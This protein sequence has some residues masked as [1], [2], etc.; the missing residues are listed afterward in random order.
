[1]PGHWQN[2]Q[3]SGAGV[4]GSAVVPFN[5][6]LKSGWWRP[7]FILAALVMAVFDW[8]E[9]IV[10]VFAVAPVLI[11]CWGLARSDRTGLVVGLV[12][13]ALA[14]WI[15][16]PRDWGFSGRWVP[17]VF[18]VCLFLPILTVVI[19]RIGMRGVRS[20]GPLRAI[21]LAAFAVVGFLT[22]GYVALWYYAEGVTGG[23]GVWPGPSGLQVVEGPGEGGSG[24]MSRRLDATG[25][26]A[27]ERMRDYLMSRGFVPRGNGTWL[28]RAN[29]IVL[30]Y[31]VCATVVDISPTEARV[32]WSV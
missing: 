31:K 13:L 30:T 24:G 15:L 11:W 21:G 3:M 9:P 4:D 5:E 23:E 14:A 27:A 2:G 10:A 7:A 25:D 32:T 17:S 20:R 19:C 28:C 29:G 16:L 26:R 12:M 6:R 8:Y 1:M 22:A 18:D